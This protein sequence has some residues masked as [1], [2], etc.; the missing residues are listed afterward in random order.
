MRVV[1]AL[2]GNALIRRGE[3]TDAEVRR[4]RLADAA[5][6]LAPVARQHELIITHGNGPPVGL[7]GFGGADDSPGWPGSPE[8]LDAQTQG[9]VGYELVEAI[10]RELP[11]H[12]VAC[13]LT[14]TLAVADEPVGIVEAPLIERLIA[15]NVVLVCAAGAGTGI[16]VHT[17]PGGTRHGTEAV[18]DRDLTAGRLA[19]QVGADRL[20]LLTDVKTVVDGWGS[21]APRPIRRAGPRWFR[22]HHYAAGSMG[23]KVEAACRF[24]D[25]TGRSAFIGALEDVEAIVAGRAGTEVAATPLPIG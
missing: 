10:Q 2:G 23:P 24:V 5:A 17:G 20:V 18:V 12:E 11:D 8:A 9:L 6:V 16:L 15:P 4:H 21:G 14:R 13:L 19:E 22:R 25:H 1:A 7:L 3:G